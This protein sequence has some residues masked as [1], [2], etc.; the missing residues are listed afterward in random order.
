MADSVTLVLRSIN[1]LMTA[2]ISYQPTLWYGYTRIWR[3]SVLSKVVNPHEGGTETRNI[4]D[5][6]GL[7][8]LHCSVCWYVGPT[9]AHPNA[10][11]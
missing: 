9:L 11:L 3:S 1:S 7:F 8:G 10:C 4:G 2:P 6:A 5:N